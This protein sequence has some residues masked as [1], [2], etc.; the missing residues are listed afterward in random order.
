M[1]EEEKD[2]FCQ[3]CEKIY[4]AIRQVEGYTDYADELVDLVCEMADAYE[5]SKK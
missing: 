5:D 2:K 1:T 4:F 3:D